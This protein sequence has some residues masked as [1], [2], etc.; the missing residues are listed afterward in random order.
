MVI[1]SKVLN[2]GHP[3]VNPFKNIR[4]DWISN[5]AKSTTA[6]IK[7]MKEDGSIKL[8]FRLSSSGRTL[9]VVGTFFEFT[10]D[11]DHDH[12][13]PGNHRCQRRRRRKTSELFFLFKL[14]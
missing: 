12:Y 5:N 2:S 6:N 3:D 10:K 13:S 11:Q 14:T 8:S 4:G 1:Y 7:G 9:K